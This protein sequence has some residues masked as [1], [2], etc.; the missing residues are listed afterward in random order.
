MYS[1]DHPQVFADFPILAKS[2]LALSEKKTAPITIVHIYFL[3]NN[4]EFCYRIHQCCFVRNTSSL[5]PS[6][7]YHAAK[8]ASKIQCSINAWKMYYRPLCLVTFHL[9]LLPPNVQVVVGTER[10]PMFKTI[11]RRSNFALFAPSVPS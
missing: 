11:I 9:Q 7:L 3:K 1:Q 6:W 2:N 10:M 8:Q 4:K 5:T